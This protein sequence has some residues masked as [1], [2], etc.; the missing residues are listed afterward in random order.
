MIVIDAIEIYRI[1]ADVLTTFSE[2]KTHKFNFNAGVF[3]WN[4]GGKDGTLQ[5]CEPN[6]SN[7]ARKIHADIIEQLEK[8]SFAYIVRPGFY[9]LKIYGM[10]RA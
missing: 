3:C 1:D 4:G 9:R 6:N 2:V 10:D 5:L 7:K 8:N